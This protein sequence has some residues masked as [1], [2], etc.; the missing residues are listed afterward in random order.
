MTANKNPIAISLL[1]SALA[2]CGGVGAET[3]TTTD[4]LDPNTACA[5]G[6]DPNYT[7]KTLTNVGDTATYVR[8][9][10]WIND[11]CPDWGKDR[12]TTIVDF[13]VPNYYQ[14]Q[15]PETYRFTVQASF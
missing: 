14:H 6:V 5:T 9:E 15:I 11:I 4:N 7:S 8:S 1:T 3:A 10:A 13:P 2:A 12:K